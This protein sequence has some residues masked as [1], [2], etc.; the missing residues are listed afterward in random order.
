M[1]LIRLVIYTKPKNKFVNKILLI[2]IIMSMFFHACIP[3][4]YCF[5]NVKERIIYLTDKKSDSIKSVNFNIENSILSFRKNL[6]ISPGVRSYK[7]TADSIINQQA[8]FLITTNSQIWYSLR[9]KEDDWVKDTVF[10]CR[11]LIR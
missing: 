1:L 6:S 4:S 11:Y 10:K 9:L 3:K 5:F 2:A 8:Y 7:I